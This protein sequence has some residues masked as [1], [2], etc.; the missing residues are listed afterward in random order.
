MNFIHQIRSKCGLGGGGKKSQTFVDF[1][2]GS[3]L[4]WGTFVCISWHLYSIEGPDFDL[5]VSGIWAQAQQLPSQFVHTKFRQLGNV[6]R[7]LQPNQRPPPTNFGGCVAALEA[8]TR[9]HNNYI[10]QCATSFPF[11]LLRS[12]CNGLALNTCKSSTFL[13][14]R[15][16]SVFSLP[17]MLIIL[18]SRLKSWNKQDWEVEASSIRTI[19]SRQSVICQVYRRHSAAD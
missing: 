3:S 8:H 9:F 1:T 15:W 10:S 2:S 4:P 19:I 14:S 13:P 7:A 5:I 6:V 18:N 11:A 12:A 16:N 17:L